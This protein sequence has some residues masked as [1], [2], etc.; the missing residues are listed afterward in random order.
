MPCTIC[1]DA[2]NY[3]KSNPGCTY[4][5][6]YTAMRL[7]CNTYSQYK[8]QCVQVLDKYLT[9]IYEEAQLP[10]ETPSSICSENHLCNS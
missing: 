1:T 3:V 4:N 2:V 10:W 6:L 8:G 7:E 9:T 5:Q